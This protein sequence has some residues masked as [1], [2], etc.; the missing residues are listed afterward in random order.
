LEQS[1]SG[2]LRGVL[3]DTNSDGIP[4]TVATASTTESWS[5]DA[6]GNF[7][8]I[9]LNGTQTNRTHNQQN[10]VTGVGSNTLVFD[11]NGNLTT[12]EQGRTLVYDAWN[13]LVAVKNAGTTLASYT[14]DAV[15]RRIQETASGTTRD[16]FFDNWNVFEERISGTTKVQYIWNPLATNS[17]I[18]RDRDAD[19]NQGNGLEERLWVQ[20]DAN[21]NVTALV[22]SSGTVVERYIY[23][24]YGQVTYLTSSFGSLSSSAYDS[25]VLYQGERLD[26]AVNQILMGF[27]VL[28]PTIQRWANPDPKGYGAR[29]NDLYRFVGDNPTNHNDPSGLDDGPEVGE[30]TKTAKV[31]KFVP[32]PPGTAVKLKPGDM[33]SGDSFVSDLTNIGFE[34]WLESN[35]GVS[36]VMSIQ[37]YKSRGIPTEDAILLGVWREIPIA[38]MPLLGGEMINGQS[39]GR[40]D[41]GPLTG[42]GYTSR[43]LTIGGDTL[44]LIGILG[45]APKGGAPQSA[46]PEGS[47]NFMG[48]PRPPAP[49]PTPPA[50]S[51]PATPPDIAP[52]GLEMPPF[53]GNLPPGVLPQLPNGGIIRPM[54]GG[55]GI[56]RPS[57]G[58]PTTPLNPPG[59]WFRPPTNL[60]PLGP[61]TP[62][63]GPPP[64]PGSP[65]SPPLS[66]N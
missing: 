17:L 10:E 60:G 34:T 6:L 1:L 56:A 38:R 59:G 35:P 8:S 58:P 54:P 2:F 32:P 3:S 37:Y 21:G 41:S 65:G 55:G 47:P 15:G 27:R 28:L 45:S 57:P 12:D 50:P 64:I 62:P 9:T 31:R 20:Q 11:K 13:R 63:P 39:I 33:T 25:R 23:D 40:G 19:G 18:L 44:L 29:D 36:A 26:P 42:W 61:Y 22:N 46:P 43:G 30:G 14:F 7:S 52:G 51:T 48:P 16:L 53:D 5:P 24:P 66:P 49:A 4:D